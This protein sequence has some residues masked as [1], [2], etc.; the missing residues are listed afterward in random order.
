MLSLKV[1]P[2]PPWPHILQATK[3]QENTTLN[4]NNENIE[5]EPT[6]DQPIDTSVSPSQVV[7][8]TDGEEGEEDTPPQVGK[9]TEQKLSD[10][11]NSIRIP[12][13]DRDWNKCISEIEKVIKL[14]P[15]HE[16]YSNPHTLRNIEQYKD[17]LGKNLYDC[18][19]NKQRKEEEDKLLEKRKRQKAQE[20]LERG[21]ELKYNLK[22]QQSQSQSQPQQS[23]PQQFYQDQPPSFQELPPTSQQLDLQGETP[24]FQSEGLNKEGE[25]EKEG[26]EGKEGK[27]GEEEEGKKGIIGK[28]KSFF[29][30]DDEEEGKGY[31]ISEEKED[32][33]D[34]IN[35]YLKSSQDPSLPA[36]VHLDDI[37]GIDN[38]ID[39]YKELVENHDLLDERF[40]KYKESQRVKNFKN[41]SLLNDK[42]ETIENL[43]N[44]VI[45][46]EK[47][48]NDYKKNSE[49]KYVSQN[50]LHDKEIQRIKKESQNENREVHKYMQR[51]LN[52]RIDNANL[53]IKDIIDE[54]KSND[55]VKIESKSKGKSKGISKKKKSIKKKKGKEKSK[56][57]S[58]S[59]RKSK[60]KGKKDRSLK[61]K[62]GA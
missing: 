7:Q 57:K 59:N 14:Q 60:S 41:T 39:N 27:E 61:K 35:S 55:D 5:G 13:I 46:L 15:S 16:E 44:I 51:L 1:P 37:K 12:M 49:K 3:G 21:L 32:M 30:G 56:S 4:I 54:T 50:K 22:P 9:T 53:V 36:T 31:E 33:I 62:K 45:K 8:P 23:Q 19:I 10:T 6:I 24:S 20:D 2:P 17:R 40:Q 34:A 18:K 48:L 11:L 52:E 25:E 47:A 26:E 42:K 38:L 29:T 28:M 43:T 58:K